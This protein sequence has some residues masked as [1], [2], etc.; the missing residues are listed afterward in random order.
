MIYKEN[1]LLMES[2]VEMFF[3]GYSLKY[4]KPGLTK[5]YSPLT[6]LLP[7]EETDLL[8]KPWLEQLENESKEKFSKYFSSLLNDELNLFLEYKS[9]WEK[10]FL[11]KEKNEIKCVMTNTPNRV[12][13][14]ALFSVLRDSN[15]P[16]IS[17]QHGVTREISK[18]HDLIE[19]NFEGNTSNYFITFN[20]E[21]ESIS[22]KSHYSIAQT[23]AA[24]TSQRFLNIPKESSRQRKPL[25]FV[26]TNL[27]RGHTS[28]FM[29]NYD[30]YLDTLEEEKIIQNILNRVSKKIDFKPYLFDNRRFPDRDFISCDIENGKYENILLIKE[31]VDMR[32]L[33]NKYEV[34]IT[35]KATST[36]SWPI[37][38]NRPTVFLNFK[39]ASPLR[40]EV[41]EDFKNG[42]FLFN[43]E[44]DDDYESVV[45]FLNLPIEE[46][47]K[48]WAKK[49]EFRATLIKKYFS[50][51]LNEGAKKAAKYLSKE[52]SSPTYS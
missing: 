9:R 7:K 23:F 1:D 11:T 33:L 28:F 24:G 37:L 48:Q 52:L 4:I 42:I 25:V 3:R 20:G 10:A 27:P 41:L 29:G 47:K 51:D 8:I 2:A 40:E 22:K 34:I 39:H 16:L 30:D 32:Y 31:K 50:D 13:S 18:Y 38:G 36:V 12:D 19:I 6:S 21:A 17:F 45:K 5:N 43:I 14:R 46:I 35:T 15:I 26:S 44:N 49:S